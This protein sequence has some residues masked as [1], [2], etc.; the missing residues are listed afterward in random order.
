MHKS[1]NLISN[2]KVKEILKYFTKCIKRFINSFIFEKKN[3]KKNYLN[4]E[5]NIIKTKN[6]VIE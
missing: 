2:K 4:A 6:K 1:L 5:K 3:L